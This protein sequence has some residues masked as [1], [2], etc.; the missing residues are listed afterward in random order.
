VLAA[1]KS[2]PKTLDSFYERTLQEIAEEDQRHALVILYWVAYAAREVSLEELAEAIVVQPQSL[3][4][5][6]IADRFPRTEMVLEILP[7]GL[8]Q[9]W[10]KDNVTCV[11]LAHFSV[12]EY[13]VSDRI[14]SSTVSQYQI[15]EITANTTI[16]EI[17]LAYLLQIGHENPPISRSLYLQFPLLH[18]A[19][20][21]WS[22]HLRILQAHPRTSTMDELSLLFLRADSNAWKIWLPF[23]SLTSGN[24]FGIPYLEEMIRQPLQYQLKDY[25]D[26]SRKFEPIHPLSW[27]SA[28]GHEDQVEMLLA[29]TPDINEVPMGDVLG[30]PLCAASRYGKVVI[31]RLLLGAGAMIDFPGCKIGTALHAAVY[32]G[33][34]EMINLL[35][36]SGAD[37]NSACGFF[38]TPLTTAVICWV[39]R[40]KTSCRIV[41]LLLSH[42]AD[43]CIPPQ[44][45]QK[46][47]RLVIIAVLTMGYC[48]T[49]ELL[50]EKLANMGEESKNSEI[51]RHSPASQGRI[52]VMQLLRAQWKRISIRTL[53]AGVPMN[54]GL[55]SSGMDCMKWLLESCI[56]LDGTLCKPST[57]VGGALEFAAI[58]HHVEAVE[59][60][61]E[62][63][64][65][66]LSWERCSALREKMRA[67]IRA[68]DGFCRSLEGIENQ[69]ANR[70]RQS[71]RDGRTILRLL[72]K[73][74]TELENENSTS[75]STSET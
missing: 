74:V 5:L 63:G 39:N 71:L 26:F 75:S 12:L 69:I 20:T 38:G 45:S 23:G 56:Y 60:L 22:E 53:K 16:S 57:D 59:L 40:T 36:E 46:W 61:L 8:I 21:C 10:K 64:L 14:K 58:A 51:R 44:G 48:A 37:I 41:D 34:D 52:D 3:P 31:A 62:A 42:G 2:L 30:T 70:Q 11:Q 25:D 24:A 27:A 7:V 1:L 29:K 67:R 18:Y 9:T 19:A 68:L 47:H 6:D 73:V 17:C 55:F 65:D 4:Y 13:L 15:N 43:I 49:I 50:L 72:D 28:Y 32:W 35:L 33:R 66:D 54:E